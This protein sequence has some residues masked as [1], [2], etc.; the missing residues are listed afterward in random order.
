MRC[1]CMMTVKSP[2]SSWQ[3]GIELYLSTVLYLQ[4][5]RLG[6]P[7]V[8]HRLFVLSYDNMLAPFI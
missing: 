7:A 2:P 6:V 4:G 5:A 3:G 8:I 1:C